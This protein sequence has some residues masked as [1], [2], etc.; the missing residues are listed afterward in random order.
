MRIGLIVAVIIGGLVGVWIAANVTALF[1]AA[2]IHYALMTRGEAALAVG[3]DNLAIGAAFGAMV[4]ANIAYDVW[5]G[6]KPKR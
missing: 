2:D 5:Q 4:G 6:V 3:W 1:A